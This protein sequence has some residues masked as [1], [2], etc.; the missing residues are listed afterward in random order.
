MNRARPEPSADHEMHLT[1]DPRRWRILAV[2]CTSL[3]VVMIGNTSLNVAIPTIARELRA[4][5]SQLQWIVDSY[6]L[7]FAGL[8]FSAGSLGDRFG[9]KGALQLG[10][11]VFVFSAI[12]ASAADTATAVIACRG[13]M[14]LGAAFVMPATLSIIINV[15]PSHERPKAIALW[16][17]IAGAAG[18]L[19]PIASGLLL[20]HYSWSSVFLINVPV[21]A[22]ALVAGFRLVPTSRDPARPSI[23][24]VGALLSTAGIAGLIYAIIEAPA[25]GWAGTG[26]LTT[27]FVAVAL[28]AGFSW[29][30]TRRFE[31][32]LD[33]RYFRHRGFS[34]GSL[35][36]ALVFFA[37]FGFMFLL[38]QYM[39][40]VLGYSALGT[41]L[42][43][44]PFTFVMVAIAPQTPRLV[45]R[46][47]AHRVVS[48]G[49]LVV[50]AGMALLSR[51][52]VGT[53]YWVVVVVM[54]LLASG[55]SLSMAPMTNAIMAGVPRAKA[56]VGSAMNDTSRELGGALGVAV[57][58]SL[59]NSWYTSSLKPALVGVPA[60][61]A[62]HARGSLAGALAVAA[63]LGPD[64]QR[65][66]DSARSAF[67]DG[68]AQAVLVGAAVIALAAAAAR[69]FLHVESPSVDDAGPAIASAPEPEV[70]VD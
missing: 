13:F 23:D 18:T 40:L 5:T 36:M 67:V 17:G 19:G 59:A 69:R 3:A 52:E 61:L 12:A 27:A 56:G 38:M 14:G 51:I 26:T 9:R 37:M 7:V 65:L 11:V 21:V 2:L 34:I 25:R 57:L 48:N 62:D 31:P 46:H 6:S 54:M 32:M 60:E 45:E 33:L 20:E 49:L 42:R 16:T 29:W 53:G 22:L 39:Q 64:G 15:F 4:S 68:M 47:G 63:Q 41:A 1:G 8:L 30:E 55:M 70:A 10:L 43:M 28:L 35:G 44:L 50:A 24:I 58:G 66:A